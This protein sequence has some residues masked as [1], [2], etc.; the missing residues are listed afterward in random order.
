MCKNEKIKKLIE[1]DV[2]V[3]YN[4][5][6]KTETEHK[7]VSKMI[8]DKWNKTNEPWTATKNIEFLKQSLFSLM[9]N[10]NKN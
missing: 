1:N 9:L 7:K 4:I 6:V 10:K 2:V 8:S 3:A 5:I